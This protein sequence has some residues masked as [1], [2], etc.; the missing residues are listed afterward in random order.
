M[1]ATSMV[2]RFGRDQGFRLR[3]LTI[4]Q[5]VFLMAGGLLAAMAIYF[6]FNRL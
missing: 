2:D 3:D 4:A 6:I 5:C 1:K